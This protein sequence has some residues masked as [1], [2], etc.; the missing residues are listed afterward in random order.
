MLI[1]PA[2]LFAEPPAF[3]YSLEYPS[4][5]IT[6][7][8][9]ENVKPIVSISYYNLPKL[10]R[11][12]ETSPL[13]SRSSYE[14]HTI[15]FTATFYKKLDF[16]YNY[17]PR[18]VDA[19]A[20]MRYR[21]Q[22]NLERKMSEFRAR[23]LSKEQ[24][25]KAGGLLSVN[26][27]V[28]SKTFESI[29]GEGGAGL[30]V[31]GYHQITF[32]GRSTWDNRASTAT[33]KQNKFPS[34]NMEQISRFDIN[35][36]IGSKITVSVSQDSKT[37]IPLANRIII[38]YK[39]DE[40]DVIKS[41]DAG[42]TTLSLPNTQFVGYSSQIQGLFGIK[43]AA[44]V[45]GLTITAIA[46][47]EK[48]STERSTITSGASAS[49]TYV[50][51]YAYI[52]GKI[53]DLGRRADLDKEGISDFNEKD[54]ILA[55]AVFISKSTYNTSDNTA[56]IQGKFYVDPRN[57]TAYESESYE[58]AIYPKPVDNDEYFLNISEH[59]ILFD[60]PN[61]GSSGEI[62]VWMVVKRAS[63]VI[64]TIGDISQ[65]EGP[66]VLKLIKHHNSDS[67]M[68]S[69]NYMWRNVYSLNAT[70]IDVSGLDINVYKGPVNTERSGDNLDH[71][72]GPKYIKILGLDQHNP[73]GTGDPDGLADVKN[74]NIIDAARG[75]LIFPDRKPFAP[76]SNKYDTAGLLVKVPEI[77]LY[78]N[79][80]EQPIL[81]S[82]YYIEVA[83]RSRNTEISLGKSNILENS[84]R[85]TINGT[86][87]EK[88][89]DYNIQYDYGTVTFLTEE[90]LDPN[91]NISIEFEYSPFITSE[92][93]T[94]FGIRGEYSTSQNL[95]LGSTFLYKSDKATERKPK[96][97][98]ETA[99]TMVWDGDMSF[100][101][102]PNILTKMA[103]LLPFY[104]TKNESSLGISAEIAKSFPNPNVDGIAYIDDFEG[105][106]DSYSLGIMREQ[107][108]LA[109]K[110]VGFDSTRQRA[111]M[112]WYNPW[113]PVPT[114]Q[115]WDREVDAADQGT[116][117][118]WLDYSPNKIDRRVG[119]IPLDTVNFDPR[120]N[121][122]GV[123]RYMTAGSANQDDA[124]LLE[125]RV[126]GNKGILH[127]DM[128]NIS[129]DVNGNGY[130][131]TEDVPDIGGYY[132]NITDPGEDIGIDKLKNTDEIGYDQSMNPDPDRDDWVYISGS[133]DYSHINGTENN[134]LDPNRSGRPDTEDLSRNNNLDRTNGYFSFAIDLDRGTFLVENSE[135]N[136]WRTFRIPIRDTSALDTTVGIP[137]WSQINFIR[138]W[139]ESPAGDSLEIKIA[140]ADLIQSTWDDTLITSNPLIP[141]TSKFKVAV[142]N[143][144]E[145]TDYRPPPG[146]SG[147][148]DKTTTLTEP[149]QSLLLRYDSLV[150][151]DIGMAERYLYDTPSLTGYRKLQM[152]VHGPTGVNKM[153][154][155]FRVG[156]DTANFYE[157]QTE[158]TSGWTEQNYVDIDF[159]EI[160]ALKE[161]LLQSRKINPDLPYDT[162]DNHYR[163]HG[164]PI[165]T[166]VKYLACGVINLDSTA[167]QS[168]E[169]WVDE[170]RVT[171]VRRNSG[172]AARASI[173]GNLADLINYNG[174]I[175]YK[176]SY[177]RGLSSS[178]RG[179]SQDNLG[180]GSSSTSYNYGFYFNL[181]RFLPRSLGASVPI[182]YRFNKNTEIPILRFGTDIIL[183]EQLRDQ[184]K[185]VSISKG[186]TI[187]E[188]I[189]R[190]GRNPLFSILL[191]R[192]KS[193]FSYSR[194][195]S[196]SPSVPTSFT[197]SYNITG[198]YDYT[199]ASVPN[200][201][202]FFWMQP[203]PL[204]N[205]MAGNRFY[206]LPGNINMSANFDRTMQISENSSHVRTDNLKRNFRGS[207]QLAYK[208]SD[209]LTSN[210]SFETRRDLSDP[211]LVSFRLHPFNLHL[212][213][214]T[215]YNQN[216]SVSYNPAI[217]SFLTHQMSFG[218]AY[219]ENLDVSDSS[220]NVG[221]SKSYGI[222][223]SLNLKKVFSGGPASRAERRTRMQQR[224]DQQK[225]A[226]EKKKK[227]SG[228]SAFVKAYQ[229][230]TG[231]L[232]PI[233]YD[234]NER[235]N[236]TYTG[237][238]ERAQ[239][240][241]RMG[242]SSEVGAS[243]KANAGSSGYSNASSKSTSYSLGSG[244][245]F[246]G[247]LKTDVTFSRKIDQDIVKSVNPQ[248]TV[249][250]VFPD[251]RFTI[252][253]LSTVKIFNPIIRRF[254]PRTGY[255]KS[256]SDVYNLRTG[257]K[258]SEKTTTT[259]RPLISLSFDILRGMQ[260]N[261]ST[262]RSVS[263]EN[264]INSQTG[265]MTSRS[266]TTVKNTSISTK[267]SFT[268]PAGIKF[269]LLGKIKIRSTMSIALDI[270]TRSQKSESA[271]GTKP[272]ASSG[273]Q[274]DMIIIPN[275]SYTFSSQIKGGLSAR[276]QD[277]N[278]IATQTKSHVRELRIWVDIRF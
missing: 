61:A 179:G 156:Q 146:V 119:E 115:I 219:R 240:K 107:W 137:S 42:N 172:T 103:N 82:T 66:Y 268:A 269:P 24:R 43:T 196:S 117:T 271:S 143:Q 251:I 116:H 129:E 275:I 216:F 248:K 261:F 201:K 5:Y 114:D 160:T 68:V 211:D 188:S 197:E 203:I 67:T 35:G 31:S 96:I 273:E 94:L 84:E 63:G 278:N 241:F 15:T 250:T 127:I 22:A 144:Q 36:T 151:G 214:E 244:T 242:L 88:G 118:L 147:Y 8:P 106:R 235:Y 254:N 89:K 72:S 13:A 177:F 253:P 73:D 48:G 174:G 139:V 77:Y 65:S 145:N 64:D 259:Q 247:G 123:M 3:N 19:S 232:N 125:L 265:G 90:A 41:I 184:E 14:D 7:Y 220:L 76:T 51:D 185:T 86:L 58:T 56:T 85:I 237:L 60:T 175:I 40:D 135:F 257:Y 208:I 2:Y 18:T 166:K 126:M 37:D 222:N 34:L 111:R 130:L 226:E 29:F 140:A 178:T 170:L 233:T 128:G 263:N 236:Y 161:Y 69:W 10:K 167:I 182:S 57:P 83:N 229:F 218:A 92:K 26:I 192:L 234:F 181:D 50:R 95:K 264:V 27:P 224:L 30:K 260:I 32:S 272:L 70:N 136:D 217:F 52:N 120:D 80:T 71:Q 110:P 212:G 205:K 221:A 4:S 46:S 266:R 209:N 28:K 157:Y 243:Q 239:F 59:W 47:Q 121:W 190:P 39:G 133:N 134:A 44:Q 6:A 131:E 93:K 202:P 215:D 101:V 231:W 17:V 53:Y 105:A 180:S 245:V 81:K 20:F 21:M 186:I 99:K 112:I 152:Y 91:A 149:E 204:L 154:F 23:G 277:T 45:G 267:Y 210:Y 164:Q 108:T 238:G 55:L 227:D 162:V 165:L 9:S 187:S 194:T 153:Q 97:G 191:N 138:M 252:Q 33:Y 98:Q 124:Q 79:N 155:F 78:G 159:N 25:Q 104:S 62:G 150:A 142:V 183:P 132:N 195:E 75:L 173:S 12:F 213:Q 148:Y 249:S 54:S 158:L 49:K 38:R 200:I 225:E 168:G 171:E 255:S 74:S 87:L 228:P 270:T 189:N 206:F 246:F 274:T 1:G 122:A 223:G 113:D 100:T 141:T 198:R 199:I 11:I 16:I 256:G 102:R 169:V 230:L 193:S 258:L 109:S 262:D 207:F 176:D 163:I 276:W